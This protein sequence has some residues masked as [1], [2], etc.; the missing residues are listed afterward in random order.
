MKEAIAGI[1]MVADC[2]AF[3]DRL[4][5]EGVDVHAEVIRDEYHATVWAAAVTRGIVHLYKQ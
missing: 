4:A 2:A 1:N 3:A 5:Q